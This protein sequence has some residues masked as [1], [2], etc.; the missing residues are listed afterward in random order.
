VVQEAMAE[1]KGNATKAMRAILDRAVE[2]QKPPGERSMTTGEWILYNILELKFIQGQRVRDV[3]RRLAMSESDLYRKQ[4][5][6]L[7]NVARTISTMELQA[8]RG[9]GS[10]E[11]GIDHR[12]LRTSP[13]D[14]V[15][16]N[17]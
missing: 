10:G 2:Q 5:V 15:A 16:G 4:R 14:D 1:H 6:A 11:R 3:A 9:L 13:R 8:V 7:E 12:A 17:K